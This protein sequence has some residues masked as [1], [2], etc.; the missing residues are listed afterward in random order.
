MTP[1]TELT[2]GQTFKASEGRLWE[3]DKLLELSTAIPHVKIVG[4]KDRS[5]SK[6]IAASVLRHYQA[7]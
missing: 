7:V 4:L 3:L 6:I 5:E 1:M 2:P